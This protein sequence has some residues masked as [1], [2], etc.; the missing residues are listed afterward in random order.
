MIRAHL[1]Q[2]LKHRGNNYETSVARALH[3]LSLV[4]KDQGKAAEAETILSEARTLR[5]SIISRGSLGVNLQEKDE[6]VIFDQMVT[7]WAGRFGGKQNVRWQRD[8]QGEHQ[9]PVTAS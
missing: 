2:C 3:R 8:N 7:C 9:Y 4:L 1:R 5:E 6:A